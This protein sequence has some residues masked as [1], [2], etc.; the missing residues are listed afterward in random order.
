MPSGYCSEQNSKCLALS[1][2][3]TLFFDSTEDPVHPHVDGPVARNRAAPGMEQ[4]SALSEHIHYTI[5]L[6]PLADV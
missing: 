1:V 6:F 4:K 5:V 2:I 3:R